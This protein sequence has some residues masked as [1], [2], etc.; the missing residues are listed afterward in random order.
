MSAYRPRPRSPTRPRRE[1]SRAERVRLPKAARRARRGRRVKHSCPLFFV[2][3]SS[4]SS[5]SYSSSM[6]GHSMFKVQGSR[7]KVP[8][9]HP[10]IHPRRVVFDTR[11][12]H[13]PHPISGQSVRA[14]LLVRLSDC[15][16]VRLSRASASVSVTS[17][18]RESAHS[19][20]RSSAEARAARNPSERRRRAC[21]RCS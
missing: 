2:Q 3:G 16:I 1:R 7:F 14:P 10:A 8:V 4:S 9:P 6:L 13:P 15:L 20:C 5:Y 18:S 21:S 19:A 12:L 17:S 11:A